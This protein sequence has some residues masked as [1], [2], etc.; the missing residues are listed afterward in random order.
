MRSNHLCQI[1]FVICFAI[2]PAKF[3]RSANVNGAVVWPEPNE[4]QLQELQQWAAYFWHW[5]ETGEV[6]PGADGFQFS[7]APGG[8]FCGL[9]PTIVLFEYLYADQ[10][11]EEYTIWELIVD[12]PAIYAA[13]KQ[14][15]LTGELSTELWDPATELHWD[16]VIRAA[17]GVIDIADCDEMEYDSVGDLEVGI[18]G[19]GLTSNVLLKKK[20]KPC[21]VPPDGDGDG[22]PDIWEELWR[23]I[24][25]GVRDSGLG[26]HDCYQSDSSWPWGK[27]GFDC[28]DYAE[29][30]IHWLRHYLEQ[31]YPGIDVYFL[32]VTWY[33]DGHAMVVIE[34]NG[35]Y[36]LVDPQTG[37][38]L[39]PFSS[40]AEMVAAAWDFMKVWY[41]VDDPW[42]PSAKKRT[43]RPWNEPSPWYDDPERLQEF[44]DCMGIAD[45]APYLPDDY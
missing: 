20:K 37:Q 24:R 7:V 13:F 23:K 25:D 8:G 28:D 9:Q 21:P 2:L 40:W 16:M 31:D 15:S 12:N 26:F 35:V 19:E 22:V 36:F 29:A 11:T 45:P 34:E 43:S 33:G 41:G 10:L 30:M 39:G 5:R 4:A 1:I 27:P 38:T 32:W 44:I 14:H 17:D 6:L 3:A 42:L 18:G